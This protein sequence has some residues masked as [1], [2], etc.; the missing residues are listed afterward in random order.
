[1]STI[2]QEHRFLFQAVRRRADAARD[3]LR[4]VDARRPAGQLRDLDPRRAT[5]IDHL[6]IQ[7]DDRRR[8][9]GAEG[10]R[11]AA[12]MTL[13]DEGATT[14]CYARSDKHWV[15]DP[16]GIA[17]EHFHTLD[18]I[19]VFSEAGAGAQVPPAARQPAVAGKRA[20]RGLL[21]T[22]AARQGGPRAVDVRQLLLRSF[23]SDMVYNVLFICTGNSARS[24]LA[25]GLMNHLGR[26]P[27]QG[28][29]G[30][31]HPE[32]HGQS[33]RLAHADQLEHPDRRVSQQELGRVRA[34]RCAERSISRSRSATTRR[35]K[36]ARCFPASR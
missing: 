31:S 22:V 13:V 28:L 6:G 4:E 34:T 11:Q 24:I 5:G 19:P 15:T 26:G 35:A 27:L 14:C 25:E 1:M 23:M 30:G 8:T 2:C 21:R 7:T 18:D 9:D 29:V 16:Q 10:P 36:S 3:R 20:S 33:V 32:R 12:D 17:W